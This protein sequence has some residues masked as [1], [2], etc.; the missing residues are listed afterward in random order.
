[1]I[2]IEESR[3]KILSQV[4]ELD[5]VSLSILDCLEMTLASDIVSEIK[6]PPFDN[7][8][9]DGFAVISKDIERASP[10]NPI[11]LDVIEELPAG[12]ISERVIESGKI[13]RIMTGAQM[14]P[15]ADSVVPV[16]LVV[17]DGD[18]VKFTSPVK[19]GANVRR[20]G[21]DI[22]AGETVL[23]KGALLGPAEIGV[24]AS[25]GHKNVEVIRRPSVAILST[26]DEL[27]DIGE[28]LSPG[29]IRNSNSYSLASQV[30]EAGGIPVLLGIARDNKPDIKSKIEQ[31]IASDILITTGGVSVGKFDLVKTCL[32]ELGAELL[33]W[34]VAMKPGKPLT[35]GK[36]KKTLVFGVPG[37]PVA[38]MVS[39]EEFIRPAI[40]KMMGKEELFRPVV[41][42][43]LEEDIKKKPGRVHLVRCIVSR[44][45][46]DYYATTTGPQ[47]SGILKSMV[48]ANGLALIPADAT[49]LPKG[50]KV[51]VQL[52]RSLFD[53]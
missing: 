14:P 5:T 43:I 28:P 47:G 13:A 31:G 6:I 44:R 19:Q 7:S 24:L 46:G 16:E 33:F 48:L 12:K 32:E 22:D 37:N 27:L 29:K 18:S 1:M 20:A 45:D 25:L 51:K 10:E 49:S 17:E 50:S 40:L 34:K 2:T 38:T 8:A 11:K 30:M 35:F 39:F 42:A 9:M 36:L 15:G 52:I 4:S 41:D 26:G 23:K 21:E 3:E 53:R